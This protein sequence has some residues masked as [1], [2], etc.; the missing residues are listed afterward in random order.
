MKRTLLHHWSPWQLC[1]PATEGYQRRPRKGLFGQRAAEIDLR[2]KNAGKES[3]E[4]KEQ[5]NEKK[6]TQPMLPK[7]RVQSVG[8]PGNSLA[9]V[10]KPATA[11]ANKGSLKT[12]TITLFASL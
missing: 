7:K 12:E 5:D 3:K 10:H 11:S 2:R 8:V 4:G 9:V 6:Q 1:G